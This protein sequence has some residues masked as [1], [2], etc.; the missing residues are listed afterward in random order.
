VPIV[1]IAEKF[2]GWQTAVLFYL[3]R[4]ID[5]KTKGDIK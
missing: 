5:P 4:A 2:S 1:C 3:N